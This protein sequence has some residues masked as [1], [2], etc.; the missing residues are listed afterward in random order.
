MK[1]ITIRD[2]YWD[3]FDVGG[4]AMGD[5]IRAM[6]NSLPADKHKEFYDMAIIKHTV[7]AI[8]Q[9]LNEG[10][11]LSDVDLELPSSYIETQNG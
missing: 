11:S 8:E 1:K 6:Q 2:I 4:M 3:K 10:N 9:I 7:L 5:L